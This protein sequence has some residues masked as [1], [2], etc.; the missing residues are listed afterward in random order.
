MSGINP[1]S[2]NSWPTPS[3]SASTAAGKEKAPEKDGFSQA[4]RGYLG[5]VDGDQQAASQAIGDLLTGKSQD[6]LSVV[7]SM[8]KADLSFKLLMGVRNKVIDAYRQTINMQ[9]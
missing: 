3:L 4:L 6:V 8:A 9:I 7:T 5:Q 2:G 1:I